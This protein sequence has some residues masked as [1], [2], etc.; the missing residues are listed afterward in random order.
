MAKIGKSGR[1]HALVNC[2]NKMC[3]LG[4]S[5]STE[6]IKVLVA[7]YIAANEIR[8]SYFINR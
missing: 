4:F 1:K 3:D 7:D 2:I 6:E 8:S 5:P